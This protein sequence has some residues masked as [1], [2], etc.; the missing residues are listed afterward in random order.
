MRSDVIDYLIRVLWAEAVA[1]LE[2]AVRQSLNVSVVAHG[3]YGRRVM[4]PGSDV[5]LTF[6]FPG[7]S[8]QVSKE[9]AKLI[10]D[11][12]LFFYDLGFKVGHG[13]RSVGECLNLANENMETKT[14]LMEARLL[15][16]QDAAF[17]EFRS[18]F[19]KECMKGREE[20]FL[21]LRQDDLTKRHGKFENTPFV[22]EP[23]VKNG[24]GGLRDYQN[25]IWMTYARHRTLNPKDLIGLGLISKAGWKEVAQ[26][27]DFILRVRSEM[28]YTEK[29]SEDLLTLRLQGPVAT[30]LGYRHKK[31]LR[32]I[33]ALT[34]DFFSAQ[35]GHEL[36]T[37][38]ESQTEAGCAAAVLGGP[39]EALSG[40]RELRL[41]Q[42][43]PERHQG[44]EEEGCAEEV[45]P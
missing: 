29:R 11:F 17:K 25:L 23:H 41:P 21:R 33:E 7:N 37:D 38:R 6:M 26:A 34:G 43:V 1:A 27:Y 36:V 22:Q 32:R 10:S 40:A 5:D 4:S 44:E 45:Q 28:H 16:G 42:R 15:T 39:V 3:G 14:A 31:L 19:D 9:V 20:E 13:A 2:P 18:R 8:G 12:L 30:N 35:R 24:C